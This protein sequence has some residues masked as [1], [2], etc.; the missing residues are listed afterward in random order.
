MGVFGS[1]PD[2]KHLETSQDL[3]GL[4]RAL[5]Y[6]D[7]IIRLRAAQALSNFCSADACPALITSL[8]DEDER[9]REAS[10]NALVAIGESALP[11]LFNAM[12]DQ[13]WLVRRGATQALIKL[14]WHPDDDEIRVCFLFAQ[15]SWTEL[16]GFGKKAIPYLTEGLR[17]ENAGIRK[18]AAIALGTIGDPDGFEPLT[19]AISDPETEVRVPATLSLGKLRD[20]RAI[21]FLV[22]L[23]YD[24][25]PVIRNAAADAL[26]T[27]GMPAFEPLVAA[28][29]DSRPIARLGAIRALGNIPDARVIPPLI[30]KLEDAFPEI[31][32]GTATA[33]GEI[34]TPALPMILEVMKSGS[35]IARLASLDAFTK[36]RDERVTAVLVA[37][38][39]G[40]DAQIAQ[41]AELVLRKREG[42]NV[43]Q[44]AQ[45]D[46]R[47]SPTS[48]S[49]A[50]YWNLRQERKA[51]EQIGS[52]EMD[53]IISIIRDDDQIDRLKAILRRLNDGHPVVEALVLIMKNKDDE[54]KRR[55]VEAI[56][57]LEDISGNPFMIAL[58]DNDPFIRTVAARNLG[59]LGWMD[60][61]IPL[62]HRAC[63]DK[64]NFVQG[65]AAEAIIRM[66]MNRNLKV[67]VTEVLIRTL[68]DDSARVRAKAA[69]LLGNMGS[70]V[71]ITPL[72]LLFRDRDGQVQTSAA[73]ALAEI[74]K[75]A[76]PALAQA[77]H[78][79]DHRTRGG[80]L[81]ALAEFG[82][83][84]EAYVNEG[85]RDSNP[86]V[87]AQAKKVLY[88]LKHEDEVPR[89]PRA[90]M[91]GIPKAQQ[92]QP[93]K[94]GTCPAKSRTKKP[95]AGPGEFI[96]RLGSKDK[97]L[98][99]HA[100]NHLVAMG[101][102][103]YRPLVYAA[104]H[105]DKAIRI[106]ALA[107][108]AQFG[109][110]GAPYIEKALEDTDIEVQHSA[111]RLLN[112]LD[113]KYGLPTVGGPA[114]RVGT[115]VEQQVM[116]VTLPQKDTAPRVNVERLYP[117]DL[118]PH[119]ADPGTLI[120][121]RAG[122]AL[123]EMGEPAFLPVIYAAYHPDKA[124]RIGALQAL[125]KFGA[126]GNPHIIKALDD[127]DLDVRHAV[128]NILKEQDGK[129]G[130]PRVGGPAPAA[131]MPAGQQEAG[132]PPSA[133]GS[134][135]V[136]MEGMHSPEEVVG[137]LKSANKDIQMNAAVALVTMG[138]TA[139]P[140]LIEAFAGESK[141]I[142]STIAEIVGNIGPDAYEPLVQALH[143]PRS[144]VVSEAAGI[145]GKL[146]D[147]RAV[148]ALISLLDNNQG[149]TG[150]IAAE[151]LG[152]LSDGA[153]VD[154]LIRAL[155]NTD[156]ELQSAAV[157]ALGYIGDE[158]A[159]SSLIEAMGNDDFSVRRNAIDALISIGEPSLPGLS[160]ALVH[161]R[162]DVRSGAADCFMQMGY[163]PKTKQ[164]QIHLL[165]ANEE[166]LEL[167]KM[168]TA[169]T[170]VLI[171]FADDANEEVR[172]GAVT[173]LGK[174]GGER[175]IGTLTG[176][177]ADDSLIVR[178]SAIGALTGRGETAIPALKKAR[179]V[180]D[181]RVQQQAIDMV[182]GKL[183]RKDPS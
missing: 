117:A 40:V 154:A 107:A 115:P 20:P 145:L 98:R 141:D 179:A 63:E 135:A 70:T 175:A 27:I 155:N 94:P 48:T 74:G 136:V 124:M 11:L 159:I 29:S 85:L 43:W 125:V 153:A 80:A 182:L 164:E 173:A 35:R 183:G 7:A 24:S 26:S 111:Y 168:G 128:Y 105:P 50:E 137:L 57:R 118:I 149:G 23:F 56:D 152:Y 143:D 73:E 31:R 113:G 41:K 176:I 2:I 75:Q 69:E 45:D 89:A 119:L 38:T 32:T 17:D 34:G 67:P 3:D 104:Y 139:V 170:G 110:M 87:R 181:N 8:K 5:Q 54:I 37:A 114:P 157:R 121:E 96:S 58:Q 77:A 163:V 131:G 126:R 22:N 13:S 21:P 44:V 52:Q 93:E 109:T 178:L 122:S 134:N 129:N 9:V 171:R 16:A 106:G 28:L 33:L 88:M 165:V 127:P 166:W 39:K 177:L 116:S 174:V 90:G 156:S 36:S 180:S 82:E 60:A 68:T 79:P 47:Q 30:S 158:R 18:G 120:R 51:F 97:N 146:G 15:E 142:R 19:R 42:L 144:E 14:R 86:D 138:G 84:G 130:L 12:G 64:D 100:I 91:A 148:P 76:F 133:A 1:K 83:K 102:P 92:A 65:T 4:I 169:A 160:E 132:A 49:T 123:A 81:A 108:L 99:A 25:N 46:E 147:K 61:I 6:E 172:V 71:A 72:I 150:I 62:I 10:I 151:A 55:A 103:A 162:R 59:K 112:H 161:T 140:A 53:K 66:G 167:A 78:D 101:E 95:R